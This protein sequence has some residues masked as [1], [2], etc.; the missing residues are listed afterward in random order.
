MHENNGFS[1][2]SDEAFPERLLRTEA[3]RVYSRKHTHIVYVSD[4]SVH[5]K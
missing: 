2:L 1:T 4:T 3:T 5:G